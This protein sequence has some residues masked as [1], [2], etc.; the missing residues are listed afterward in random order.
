MLHKNSESEYLIAV[1]VAC[2]ESVS[3]P[4]YENK[5]W[6]PK[7]K[8]SLKVKLK[9]NQSREGVINVWTKKR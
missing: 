9:C 5:T 2:I 1:N 4:R 3:N 7:P 6:P 8:N